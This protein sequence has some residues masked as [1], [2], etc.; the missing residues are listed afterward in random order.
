MI[1]EQDRALPAA[2]ALVLLL[3]LA[4][5]VF[6]FFETRFP[7][8]TAVFDLN[9]LDAVEPVLDVVSFGDD[10]GLVPLT[11]GF[12][13]LIRGSRNDLVH[14]GGQV[15]V[16]FSV[17]VIL[18]IQH[19]ILQTEAALGAVFHSAITGLRYFPLKA[20]LKVFVACLGDDVRPWRGDG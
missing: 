7:V 9:D 6:A 15:I 10:A 2:E 16:D 1:L 14:R 5:A 12:D 13:R 4:L 17:R 11:Y 3:V 20:E 18:V 8:I 19:L